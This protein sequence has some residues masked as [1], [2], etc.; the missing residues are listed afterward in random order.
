LR[1]THYN[2]L[3]NDAARRSFKATDKQIKRQAGVVKAIDRLT[4]ES[5]EQLDELSKNTLG[6]YAKK[7]MASASGLATNAT[8]HKAVER[9]LRRTHYNDLANDAARRSFKAT[10]KQIKRQAGVVK[11]IDRLTKESEDLKIDLGN[12]FEGE[13]LSEEFKAK[14]TAV[15]ESAVA[16]RVKQELAELQEGFEQQIVTE[17]VEL[18]ESL[19]DKVDGYLDYMV[20]QWM[21]KNE[22]AINRGIKTEILESFVTGMKGL[23]ESHYIDVPDEKYDL[24]EAKQEEVQTLE[25]RLDEQTEVIIS[26]QQQIKEINRQIQIDEACRDMADTDAERFRQLAE[27][28][29]FT[30]SDEFQGKLSAIVESYFQATPVKSAKAKVLAEEFMT[31]EPVETLNESSEAAIDPTMAKYLRAIE[32]SGF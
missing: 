28:L 32:K 12:L 15:F 21:E 23:F 27:E 17:S 29:T 20:E 10:D 8:H 31:D 1:R 4:K 24:V 30:D 16:L 26:L 2:D 14:A 22:L 11:A 5:E 18:K 25:Q 6:S 7:A 9:E 13:E 19:V 3:A